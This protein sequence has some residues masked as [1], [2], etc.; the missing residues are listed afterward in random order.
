MLLLSSAIHERKMFV[1]T[2]VSVLR[3]SS[4]PPAVRRSLVVSAGIAACGG[5]AR[6]HH[7]TERVAV[8]CRAILPGGQVMRARATSNPEELQMFSIPTAYEE[9]RA[10]RIQYAH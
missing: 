10:N 9:K 5:N 4:L 6:T 8:E 1:T 3:D 2:Q 7:Q